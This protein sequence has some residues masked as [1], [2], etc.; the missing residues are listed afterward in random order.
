MYLEQCEGE[1]MYLRTGALENG[2]WEKVIYLNFLVLGFSAY[3]K[4]N[5]G[6]RAFKRP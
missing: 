3:I 2:N 4:V 6:H 1:K 5:L